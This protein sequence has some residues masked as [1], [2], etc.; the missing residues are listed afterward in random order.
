MLT[1]MSIVESQRINTVPEEWHGDKYIGRPAGEEGERLIEAA[2]AFTAERGKRS[3]EET[4]E[5]MKANDLWTNSTFRYAMAKEIASGLKGNPMFRALYVYGDVMEDRARFASD[6]DLV[7]HVAD[8][9]VNFE[10]WI[11]LLD[12]ELVE[13]FQSR[14]GVGEGLRM[15][16]DV[17]VVTDEEVSRRAGYGA[18]LSSIHSN[19]TQL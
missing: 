19:L 17:H 4:I 14:F 8:D 13:Q 6:V 5:R 9:K 2:L 16:L 7:L 1:K 10:A 15:L 18:M 11:E 3:D 12:E